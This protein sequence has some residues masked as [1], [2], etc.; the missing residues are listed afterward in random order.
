MYSAS[1]DSPHIEVTCHEQG[2]EFL[3]SVKDNGIGIE[4]Q[5]TN[6]IFKVFERL[7]DV[8]TPGTGIGLALAER[9]VS[10]H[11]GSLWVESTKGEGSTFS[12]TIQK[13][14]EDMHGI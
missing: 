5:Y 6:K 9:I 4:P 11:N 14:E 12:F 1:V 3:F 10:I 13:E 8:D 7:C 2:N